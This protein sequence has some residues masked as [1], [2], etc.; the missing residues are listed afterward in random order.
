MWKCDF[1]MLSAAMCVNFDV[2]DGDTMII[3]ISKVMRLMEELNSGVR[4]STYLLENVKGHVL[5]L[6]MKLAQ[7]PAD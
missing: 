5:N 7:M 3:A 6:V 2:N 1:D 4:S